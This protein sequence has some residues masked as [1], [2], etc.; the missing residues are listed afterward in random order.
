MSAPAV[1]THRH[2]GPYQCVMNVPHP[3]LTHEGGR[4]VTVRCHRLEVSDHGL[5]ADHLAQLRQPPNT[6]GEHP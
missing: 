2:V 5:C 1:V 4:P 3:H 6:A